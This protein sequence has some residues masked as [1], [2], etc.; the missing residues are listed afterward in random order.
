MTWGLCQYKD[1]HFRKTL[2]ISLGNKV[3]GCPPSSAAGSLPIEKI[4]M[5]WGQEK[6]PQGVLLGA[7]MILK[8]PAIREIMTTFLSLL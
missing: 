4:R 7:V 5:E 3:P 6:H 2:A 8:G 1:F